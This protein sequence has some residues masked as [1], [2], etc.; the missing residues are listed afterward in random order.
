MYYRKI[1]LA[2]W[3]KY[4]AEILLKGIGPGV[5]KL[6]HSEE[7]VSKLIEIAVHIIRWNNVFVYLVSVTKC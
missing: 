4:P 1:L 6:P 2:F 5:S 7:T 3:K